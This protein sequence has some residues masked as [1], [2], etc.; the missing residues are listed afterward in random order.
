MKEPLEDSQV[1]LLA[2]LASQ[3]SLT[4]DFTPSEYYAV[5]IQFLRRKVGFVNFESALSFLAGYH[6]AVLE[7][8]EGLF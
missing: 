2:E 8:K 3:D 1:T 6:E 5:Y 4:L 7:Y